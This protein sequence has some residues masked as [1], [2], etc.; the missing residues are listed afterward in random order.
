MAADESDPPKREEPEQ[1]LLPRWVP[2]LIG[3]LLVVFAALA[4]YTGSRYRGNARFPALVTKRAATAPR[5][6][7]PAPPGEL[8]PGAS[9]VLPG[10]AGSAPSAGEPVAGSSRAVIQGDAAG[11]ASV[12]RIWAR[13]GMMI[14]AEPK[15]ALVSVNDVVVGPANQLDSPDE[16]YD[17][18]AAGSYTVRVSAPGHRE[19]TF[20]VTA[21]DTATTEVARI[22]AKL[23][24]E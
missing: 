15:D 11:I 24:R 3:L 1:A 18:P 21:T 19:Q 16:T 23:K 17:F 8:E 20:V 2:V 10:N 5:A 14:Q 13:R 7:A 6:A 22:E 9:L 12:V 4:V